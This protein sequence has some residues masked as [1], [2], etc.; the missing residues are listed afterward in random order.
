MRTG[1][2]W[3]LGAWMFAA[4]PLFAQSP[5]PNSLPTPAAGNGSKPGNVTTPLPSATT[6][7]P[8]PTTPPDPEAPV[9]LN[10]PPV[11]P[12]VFSFW[13]RAEYLAYWVKNAPLPISLVTG[14]PNNPTQ[15]L[16]NSDQNYGMA[17]GFRI[18]LGVWLDPDNNLA[19]DT[20]FFSLQRRSRTFSASSD[21]TGN[22]TLAFPYIN[23]TPGTT[24]NM[25]FIT[26][27]G[28]MTGNVSVTSTMQLW[29]AEMNGAIALWQYRDV[30]NA[31]PSF[32]LT[33]LVGLRYVD[34]LE[35]LNISS[36]STVLNMNPVAMLS[37]SDS[38]NTRNQFYGGQ[39]GSRI[40]WRSDLFALDVTGK[41]AIGATHQSVDIQG[42]STQT[43]PPG[44][45]T[46]TFPG[47]L[48]AQQSNIGRVST[49]QSSVIPAVEM[50]LSMFLTSN[51]RA[52]VGYDFMYWT[53]VLRPGNQID[54][55]INLTQSTVFGNG[56][57]L[58]AAN[59]APLFSRS[60]F[61]AQGITLGF[62]FR[63]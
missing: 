58:G 36:M 26:S 41:L 61:W 47:G 35:N 42:T 56:A 16:L 39:I 38:F 53:Q 21:D 6:G 11:V 63:Y 51:L 32:E 34:L 22:P 4:V 7:T 52:F 17:S 2:R 50:K 49:N 37:L 15:E 33:G 18:S 24:M 48:F 30:G 29:G 62:E 57:L 40:N 44:V 20:N 12:E 59:P 46:G 28:L 10:T 60:D 3:I 43:G 31:Y 1:L 5:L 19:L 13:A 23:Q 54:R 14:D 8:L 45:L 27:P 25:I 55:N 9:I